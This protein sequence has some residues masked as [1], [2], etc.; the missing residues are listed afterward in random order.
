[1]NAGYRTHHFITMPRTTRYSAAQALRLIWNTD[2]DATTSNEEE[3]ENI[4]HGA[5]NEEEQDNV[6]C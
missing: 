4:A 6:P 1:M 5:V 2:E 3:D